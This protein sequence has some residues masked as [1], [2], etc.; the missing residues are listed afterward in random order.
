MNA[1][2]EI[3]YSDGS[4]IKSPVIQIWSDLHTERRGNWYRAFWCESPDATEGSPV[5]GYC[6]PGGSQRT[7][8]AAAWE[9][10]RLYRDARIY[11]N[12]KEVKLTLIRS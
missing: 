4:V 11:R 3:K 6:S 5:I 10:R 2:T 12:G 8:R 7:I 1:P 9:V